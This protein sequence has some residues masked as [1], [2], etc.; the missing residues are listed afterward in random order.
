[1]TVSNVI[2][3][4][5]NSVSGTVMLDMK[6]KVKY[7]VFDK[8]RNSPRG[9]EAAENTLRYRVIHS[10]MLVRLPRSTGCLFLKADDIYRDIG[11]GFVQLELMCL[12]W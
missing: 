10:V 7:E 11:D 1:M 4:Q 5:S 9:L 3:C 8:L 2:E 12:P 6:C